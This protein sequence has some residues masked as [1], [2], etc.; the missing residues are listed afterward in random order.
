MPR[1]PLHHR[2]LRSHPVM[3]WTP[4]LF[5]S[6]SSL[7][8]VSVSDSP[9]SPPPFPHFPRFLR[10]ASV[11]ARART[12]AR[13][14]VGLWESSPHP[15]FLSSLSHLFSLSHTRAHALKSAIIHALSSPS[16]SPTLAGRGWVSAC[17]CLSWQPLRL[18]SALLTMNTLSSVAG[19]AFSI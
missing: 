14:V 16:Q 1:A 3:K 11:R 4:C 8:S 19:R 7:I 17:V 12:C 2:W 9:I 5:S 10:W 6:S 18:Q 13:V 15:L